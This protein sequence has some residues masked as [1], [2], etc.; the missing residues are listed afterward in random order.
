MRSLDELSNLWFDMARLLN[1]E[2]LDPTYFSVFREL[3]ED[4][5]TRSN[6]GILQSLVAYIRSELHRLSSSVA[7]S[8]G[9]SMATIWKSTR[10]IVPSNLE[11]WN[12]YDRLVR[13]M[14]QFDGMVGLQIGIPAFY[15]C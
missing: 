10:P 4:W 15:P 6:K 1:E 3:L 12:V 11:Q 5:I 9:I 14:N 2:Y 8:T 7:L 13:L